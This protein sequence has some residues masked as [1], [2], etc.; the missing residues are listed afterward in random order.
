MRKIVEKECKGIKVNAASSSVDLVKN[1]DLIIATTTSNTPVI[2]NDKD[3][4]KGKIFIGV[5]S[6]KP[7]MRE[8]PDALFYNVNQ[9]FVDTPMAL[10]ESGDLQIPISH[11]AG[12]LPKLQ[13][14]RLITHKLINNP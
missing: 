7:G 3:L 10:K 11:I 9:I 8:F 2:D 1:S 6:Y 4:L 5:G 13:K 12:K 14:K